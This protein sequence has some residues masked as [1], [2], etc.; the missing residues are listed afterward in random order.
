MEDGNLILWQYHT[1]LHTSSGLVTSA[2]VLSRWTRPYYGGYCQSRRA[3]LVTAVHVGHV[4]VASSIPGLGCS[5]VWMSVRP[6][7]RSILYCSRSSSITHQAHCIKCPIDQKQS[8]I[9][10]F[11][12]SELLAECPRPMEGPG[13]SILR[14]CIFEALFEQDRISV[15][16]YYKPQTGSQH[17][18]QTVCI[19]LV[20]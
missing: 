17:V 6:A 11:L 16:F 4:D 20:R 15:A 1:P 9:R 5:P 18:Y 19:P 14:Q 2:H 13:L 7:M 10:I 8:I 12:V 3:R